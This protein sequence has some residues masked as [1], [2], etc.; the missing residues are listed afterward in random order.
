MVQVL[1]VLGA[2]FVHD[3]AGRVRHFDG[4]KERLSQLSERGD[5]A[6][7]RKP[8]FRTGAVTVGGSNR[9]VISGVVIKQGNGIFTL[10]RKSSVKLRP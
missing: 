6:W 10:V 1:P 9:P 3:P 7:H 2:I 4:A 5:I 8:N